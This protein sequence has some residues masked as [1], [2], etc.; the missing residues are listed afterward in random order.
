M[1]E[2]ILANFAW[3]LKT[4]LPML[5][6]RT[7]TNEQFNNWVVMIHGAGGSIE[8]WYRQVADFARHFNVLL[9]DLVGHGGS[10]GKAIVDGFNFS[11]AA[12]QVMEV[13]DHLKI[14][15]CH[16]MGLSLG[17]IVVRFIA[18]KQPQRVLSMVM[19]GAVTKISLKLKALLHL[20]TTFKNVVPYS[21]L[22]R[23][24]AKF[25]IPQPKYSKSK[26]IFLNSAQKVS[27]ESF[28]SWLN[29]SDGLGA[30]IRCLFEENVS[31][32]TLYIM[33]EDDKLFLKHVRR[34][35]S[36]SGGNVSLAIVPNA[37]HVCN[38]DNKGCFNQL[39]IDFI[40]RVNRGIAC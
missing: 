21:I 3:F 34:T 36:R 35:V 23:I 32:P 16:F 13:V 20:T 19:A 12:D 8:V 39:S 10:A 27:F 37:G 33:G 24:F 7:I 11:K 9:V 4:I 2:R 40:E 28:T 5:H 22:K 29:L 26:S 17:S 31:I 25:I 15:K 38:I 18:Q 1:E 6:Y 14:E 30:R